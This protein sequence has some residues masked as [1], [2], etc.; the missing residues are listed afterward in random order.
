VE[1][2]T[3]I[4]IIIV[5]MIVTAFVVFF[6]FLSVLEAMPDGQSLIGRSEG[7][8]YTLCSLQR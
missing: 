8:L 2:N 7:K 3:V 5:I 4:I 1:V 6:C